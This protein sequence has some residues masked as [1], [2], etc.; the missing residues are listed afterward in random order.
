MA[1]GRPNA[2]GSVTL[3]QRMV[4]AEVMSM[5]ISSPPRVSSLDMGL[6]SVRTKSPLPF[7]VCASLVDPYRAVR[8]DSSWLHTVPRI[9]RLLYLVQPG[10]ALLSRR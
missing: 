4:P 8:L 3:S 5:V 2:D 7:R 1:I 10:R 6:S 9:S